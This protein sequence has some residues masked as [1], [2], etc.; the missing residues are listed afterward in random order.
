MIS[1]MLGVLDGVVGFVNGVEVIRSVVMVGMFRSR[2]IGNSE[3]LLSC[4]FNYY[5]VLI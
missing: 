4:V 3:L 1:R 5:V 2:C